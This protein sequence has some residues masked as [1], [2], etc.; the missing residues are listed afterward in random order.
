MA[1]TAR[2]PIRV[3]SLFA[4]LQLLHVDECIESSNHTELE[5]PADTLV[6]SSFT[7]PDEHQIGLDTD[8]SFVLYPVGKLALHM[9]TGPER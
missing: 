7:H 9:A 5:Q 3:H 6:T 8:R 2:G 1:S 4:R